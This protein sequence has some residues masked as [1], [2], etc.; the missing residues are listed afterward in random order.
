VYFTTQKS[1]FLTKKAGQ[2]FVPV[3]E[4]RAAGIQMNGFLHLVPVLPEMPSIYDVYI[5]CNA[6]GAGKQVD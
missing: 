3:D 2:V 1:N 4:E 6:D 5:L